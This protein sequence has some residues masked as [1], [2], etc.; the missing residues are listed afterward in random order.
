MIILS[1]RNLE[2]LYI[3]ITSKYLQTSTKP[4]QTRVGNFGCVDT[5]SSITH[6]YWLVIVES[7]RAII[8]TVR[9]SIQSPNWNDFG[10]EQ[11]KH[12]SYIDDQMRA[13]WSVDNSIT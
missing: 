10:I 4:S 5:I 13:I 7:V 8:E 12:S 1:I 6:S 11:L 3:L 9:N 2:N